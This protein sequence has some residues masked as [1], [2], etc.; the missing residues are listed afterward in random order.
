MEAGGSAVEPFDAEQVAGTTHVAQLEAALG[1]GPQGDHT[2]LDDEDVMLVR[3]ALRED[4]FIPLVESDAAT[5]GQCQHIAI[6]HALKR[7]VFLEKVSYAIADGRGV[8]VE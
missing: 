7:R 2:L 3:L 1:V 4:V 8:H 5:A 6:V